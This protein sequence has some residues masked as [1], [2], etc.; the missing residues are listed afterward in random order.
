MSSGHGQTGFAYSTGTQQQ[1]GASIEITELKGKIQDNFTR[2]G[3]NASG[4]FGQCFLESIHAFLIQSPFLYV[5]VD[6]VGDNSLFFPT[7]PRF[8]W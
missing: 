6:F 4:V 2:V 5:F 1:Q 3:T 8:G 7:N